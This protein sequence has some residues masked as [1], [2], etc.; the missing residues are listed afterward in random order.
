MLR[1]PMEFPF[2]V[3]FSGGGVIG[4]TVEL[5]AA[6]ENVRLDKRTHKRVRPW[7]GLAC[8]QCLEVVVFLGWLE[9]N[10][11]IRSKVERRANGRG[12]SANESN[13]KTFNAGGVVLFGLN[14]IG[15]S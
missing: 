6:T 12:A 2:G 15:I 5:D 14:A 9:R 10:E 8:F 13:M 11:E 1:H 3:K 7:Q 4:G